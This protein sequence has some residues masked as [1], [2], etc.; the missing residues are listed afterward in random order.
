MNRTLRRTLILVAAGLSLA[1][2]SAVAQAEDVE[3]A[4][5][6]T[7]TI[8]L[9]ELTPIGLESLIFSGFLTYCDWTFQIDAGLTAGAFDTVKVKGTG[10]LGDLSLNST[11][12]V[13]PSTAA[14]E[15]WK[16]G[17]AWTLADVSIVDTLYLADPQS[18]SYNQ[19]SIS[20]ANEQLTFQATGK[21]GLCP[22]CFLE[23]NVCVGFPLFGC[24]NGNVELCTLFTDSGGFAMTTIAITGYTLFD[25]VLGVTGT[26]DATF[27]FT[28]LQKSLTP[29]VRLV[30]DW[31][32]CPELEIIA[33][34]VAGGVP[35]HIGAVRF[36]GIKGEFTIGTGTTFTIAESFTDAI[37]A[38][39]TGKTDFFEK[40][41]ITAPLPSCCGSP[42]SLEIDVYFQRA[43]VTTLFGWGLLE[44]SASF[45]LS[46]A[47]G[48][49]IELF[50][51]A[52]SPSW[53]LSITTQ[54]L[55]DGPWLQGTI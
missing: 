21:A 22:L 1:I 47:L 23:A 40:I 25:D 36:K 29:I 55:W 34:L 3:L 52:T 18:A 51:S 48:F 44:A 17:L 45:H 9:G 43:P 26:L 13:D 42:G 39:I 38:S 12:S 11:L 53:G 2:P 7:A 8:G 41:G 27:Q 54:I 10:I 4:G 28:Q 19:I 14:F 33:E 5:M 31:S 6:A 49:A 30:P 35:I 32:I 20:G 46:D 50:H 15:S 16:S 37:N 24:D